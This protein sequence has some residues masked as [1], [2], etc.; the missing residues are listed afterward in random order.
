[1]SVFQWLPLTRAFEWLFL[2]VETWVSVDSVNKLFPWFSH[3]L[4]TEKVPSSL[5]EGRSPIRWRIILLKQRG[6]CELCEIAET[7]SIVYV[8]VFKLFIYLI[9]WKHG[10]RRRIAKEYKFKETKDITQTREKVSSEW[11]LFS[12]MNFATCRSTDYSSC[13]RIQSTTLTTAT[14]RIYRGYGLPFTYIA[15]LARTQR[16][17]SVYWERLCGCKAL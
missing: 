2:S 6:L 7:L 10:S 5:N 11:R 13:C 4:P 1:M 9:V 16:V 8:K 14:T 12:K 15:E 3:A 17:A